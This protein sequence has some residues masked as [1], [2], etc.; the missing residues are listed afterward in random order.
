MKMK[1]SV[2]VACCAAAGIVLAA[3][4]A[5][6]IQVN[7]GRAERTEAGCWKITCP[8]GVKQVNVLFPAPASDDAASAMIID[9]YSPDLTRFQG[10]VQRIIAAKGDG[11]LRYSVSPLHSG[12]WIALRLDRS[13]GKPVNGGVPDWGR[14]GTVKF[15]I[16]VQNQEGGVVFLGDPRVERKVAVSPAKP[17][18][19]RLGWCT[20]KALSNRMNWDETAAFMKKYGFTD[21]I[22]LVS[23]AAA[24][25][26]DSK[27]MTKAVK[28]PDDFDNL[29]DGLAAARKYGLKYHAWRT[30]WQVRNETPR[31]LVKQFESEGRFQMTA[32]GDI[33]K[34]WLCPS[35]PRNRKLEF[36]GYR[37]LVD[38]GV[39]GIHFDYIRY[40]MEDYCFCPRCLEQ[41][42]KEIGESFT[43]AEAIRANPAVLE[44]WSAFRAGLI[45]SVV[46]N[47]AQYARANGKEVSAA[48]QRDAP[49][50]YVRKGQDW[51]RWCREGWLD[52]VCPM[53]Y[54]WSPDVY[55]GFVLRQREWLKGART[56]FYPGIGIAYNGC[57]T[58]MPVENV[59]EELNFLRE[60]EVDGF[61]VFWTGEF[62][63][64]IL[65]RVLGQ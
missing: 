60:I 16:D 36:D 19:R 10:F 26:Y 2:A 38:S 8:P 21:M 43:S 39:D 31:A 6:Q 65:P 14:L 49:T 22:V 27:V 15:T 32:S 44:K 54:Y 9:F 37:E 17:G 64:K 25:F 18:E 24:S 35:D 12:E 62:A 4:N 7:G 61:A 55:R 50:D 59:V 41:F 20:E 33:D 30:N 53:D 63:E 47:V 34:G 42:S 29:R 40:K 58:G 52:F 28:W 5:P 48:L 13:Q 51:L 3:A 11:F 45:S 1:M 46:S 56:K 57:P 23:R